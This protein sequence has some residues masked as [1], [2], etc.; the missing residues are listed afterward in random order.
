MHPIHAS[1]HLYFFIFNRQ[2]PLLSI[3][4][5]RF[6]TFHLVCSVIFSFQYSYFTL[7]LDKFDPFNSRV[8]IFLILAVI[9]LV[10][11][12]V[13]VFSVLAISSIWRF[14]KTRKPPKNTTNIGQTVNFAHQHLYCCDH[15]IHLPWHQPIIFPVPP[16][17]LLTTQ[18]ISFSI[19]LISRHRAS[20]ILFGACHARFNSLL[21]FHFQYAISSIFNHPTSFS[22]FHLAYSVTFHST[23]PT[24]PSG[25]INLIYSMRGFPNS[26]HLRCHCD[27]SFSVLTIF[28]ILGG[29]KIKTQRTHYTNW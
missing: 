8:P 27:N 22:H 12:I 19:V 15:N 13:I 1:I 10:D 6:Q 4:Q 18:S 21:I 28:C 7:G 29:F 17:T 2:F 20:S 25:W 26:S 11:V 5:L 9:L 16:S 3:T 14:S 24:L 23:T